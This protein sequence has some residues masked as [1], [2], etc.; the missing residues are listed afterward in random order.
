MANEVKAE[1]AYVDNSLVVQTSAERVNLQG[2]GAGVV[3]T[4]RAELDN[5]SVVFLAADEVSGDVK[6]LIDA[7]S[8]AII[9]L[10]MGLVGGL[11]RL[12]IRSKKV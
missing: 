5:S 9:G 12:F 1:T 11:F 10:V 7:R 8:A 4:E 2:S 3:L 6:V